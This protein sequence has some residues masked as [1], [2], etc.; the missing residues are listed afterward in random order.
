MLDP[1]IALNEQHLRR[2]LPDYVTYFHHERVHDSLAKNTPH[3]R[4][5][6]QRLAANAD[7]MSMPRLVVYI[8]ATRG[9]TRHKSSPPTSPSWC[10]LLGMPNDGYRTAADASN[11]AR[12]SQ[13]LEFR[14]SS[15]ISGSATAGACAPSSTICLLL[16]ALPYSALL[17]DSSVFRVAPSR[18]KPAKAPFVRP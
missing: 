10:G 14:A 7:V 4:P 16:I 13:R 18:P 5:V 15:A 17:L 6:E 1:V 9:E 2:L 3:Q 11:R 8:I 12:L